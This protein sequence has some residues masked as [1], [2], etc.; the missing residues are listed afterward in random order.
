MS[1]I[2]KIVNE[3]YHSVGLAGERTQE[4]NGGG[5]DNASG[6]AKAYDFE[7]VN[8]LLTAKA[9]ALQITEIRIAKL[10]ALWNGE[11]DRVTDDTE[12]VKYP[13]EFD[14][15]GLYDEFEIGA[16]L[17]LLAAPDEVRRRQMENLTRKLFPSASDKDMEV[18]VTALKS[19]PPE[20]PL[21]TGLGAKPGSTKQPGDAAN[22]AAT[23]KTAKELA[24]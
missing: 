17:N 18:M 8:S 14:T 12:L 1:C 10:V 24:A 2:G 6:V 23:Q 4:D 15:R 22:A 3:I 16:R 9:D 13:R 19:W 7:K 11:Q 5:I 20:V 21:T